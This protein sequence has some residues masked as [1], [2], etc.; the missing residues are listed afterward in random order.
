M[1]LILMMQPAAPPWFMRRLGVFAGLTRP[2][3]LMAGRLDGYA[4]YG[5]YL[6]KVA[7]GVAAAQAA[8]GAAQVDLVCHSAGGWL[9]RAFLADAHDHPEAASASPHPAVASVVTLGTPHRVEKGARVVDPTCGALGWVNRISPGAFYADRGV[10][11]VSVAGKAVQ[12]R[13][14]GSGGGTANRAHGAYRWIFGAGEAFGD[15]IVPL[16]AALLPGAT[17]V[18][19]QGVRHAQLNARREQLDANPWYGDE[20]VVDMWLRHLLPVQQQQQ[21]QSC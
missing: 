4:S 19:L 16:S 7:A 15:S 10:R 5:W 14:A 21:Q 20:R 13:R 11:Y 17:H 9:A 3:D 6:R 2:L 8:T 1:C 18:T 12:G